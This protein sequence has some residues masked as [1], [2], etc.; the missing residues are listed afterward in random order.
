LAVTSGKSVARTVT[1]LLLF[2]LSGIYV[3]AIP[4][5]AYLSVMGAFINDFSPLATYVTLALFIALPGVVLAALW[6]LGLR[7]T[8]KARPPEHISN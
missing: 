3:T 7:L 2:P 1:V 4:I 5:L 8:R 6:W